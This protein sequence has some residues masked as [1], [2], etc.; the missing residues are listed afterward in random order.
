MPLPDLTPTQRR[1]LNLLRDGQAHTPREIH[2]LLPD[3]L[4]GPANVRQ[5]LSRLR[6]KLYATGQ[7][8]RTERRGR[9]TAYRL[10]SQSQ[11]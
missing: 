11:A 2:L 7:D 3:D 8:I 6:R 1:V 10:I 9:H 5:H 4:G